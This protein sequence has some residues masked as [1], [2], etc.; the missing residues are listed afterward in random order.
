MGENSRNYTITAKDP[1]IESESEKEKKEQDGEFSGA[2]DKTMSSKTH[3]VPKISKIVEFSRVLNGFLPDKEV[4]SESEES[5]PESDLNSC[6][7]RRFWG[8]KKGGFFGPKKKY[9]VRLCHHQNGIF[10]LHRD[11]EKRADSDVKAW[12]EKTLE[13]ESFFIDFLGS[14]HIKLRGR[15]FKFRSDI[16]K[17]LSN[18]CVLTMPVAQKFSGDFLRTEILDEG[19]KYLLYDALE[20][21]DEFSEK[22]IQ[23]LFTRVLKSF[24]DPESD[25][26][27]GFVQTEYDFMRYF[28]N[29]YQTSTQNGEL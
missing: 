27:H 21:T 4:K 16:L 10:G 28:P 9:P 5:R 25:D 3:H 19:L 17:Y 12:L 24:I 11:I 13:D 20:K 15:H 2:S 6:G 1:T 29:V 8:T 23:S 26:I 7:F 22:S 18:L 14:V